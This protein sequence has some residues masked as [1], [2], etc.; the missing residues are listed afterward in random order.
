MIHTHIY[1]DT[2]IRHD[3]SH[4]TYIHT[5]IYNDLYIYIYN[6]I[7]HGIY[8]DINIYIYIYLNKYIYIY[9]STFAGFATFLGLGAKKGSKDHGRRRRRGLQLRVCGGHP[10]GVLRGEPQRAGT[11]SLS[12][13]GGAWRSGPKGFPA[14]HVANPDSSNKPCS[15]TS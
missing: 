5:Y 12:T 14:S 15:I 13:K 6:D 7:Y 3:I 1:N 10:Q 8:N 11:R 2:Y 4:D 9:T